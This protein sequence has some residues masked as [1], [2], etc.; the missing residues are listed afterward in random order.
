MGRIP[1]LRPRE[2]I[3]IL[4]RM[5]FQQVRQRGSHRHAGNHAYEAGPPCRPNRSQSRVRWRG[6]GGH[7]DTSRRSPHHDR[8]SLEVAGLVYRSEILEW[9]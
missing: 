7:R 2:V 9:M 1:V 5:G 3:R 8:R 6:A 4:E